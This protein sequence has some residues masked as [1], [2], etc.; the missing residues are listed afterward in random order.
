MSDY[1]IEKIR[2]RISGKSV[3]NSFFSRFLN[4][5]L[6]TGLITIIC[7]IVLKSNSFLKD[8]FYNKV[9][10]VNFNFAYVNDLYGRYFGGVLP[11]SDFFSET[12]TVF[13]E[14][15]SYDGYSSYLDGVSLNVSS[16]YLVPS[17]DSGLVVFVGEKEGYGNTVIVETVSGVDMWYSNMSS[18][19]VDMYE[20]V[21]RGDFLGNCD[22]NLYLVFKKD[23][24]VLDYQEY[25]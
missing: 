2:R 24:N 7:L 16:N 5:F 1:E 18:I 14:T 17:L 3:S 13:N 6:I 25:I 12:T 9:L 21:S 22:N 10:N 20:Y 15:L 4:R 23:G 8:S 11:F 19:S